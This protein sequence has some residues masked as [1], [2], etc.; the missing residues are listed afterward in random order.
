MNSWTKRWRPSAAERFGSTWRC[1]TACA[2]TRTNCRVASHWPRCSVATITRRYY[3]PPMLTH[4]QR[5]SAARAALGMD[6]SR[7][8]L[9]GFAALGWG[10]RMPGFEERNTH[11]GGAG[12]PRWLNRAGDAGGGPSADCD[13]ASNPNRAHSDRAVF[14][15]HQSAGL[16]Q[17][18]HSAD[19]RWQVSPTQR[20][21]GP[22]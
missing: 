8:S 19:N 11:F 22:T 3:R 12:S 9:E 4:S 16:H 10:A 14:G 7:G 20:R 5:R 18:P 13:G 1:S 17:L 15:R 6:R 2:A 21:V